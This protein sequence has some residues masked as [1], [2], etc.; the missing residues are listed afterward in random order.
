MTPAACGTHVARNPPGSSARGTGESEEHALTC[1]DLA[2][3][4]TGIEPA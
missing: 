2:E 3:R 4:A 1:G